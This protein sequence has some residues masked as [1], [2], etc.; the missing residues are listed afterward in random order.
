MGLRLAGLDFLKLD[1]GA[2]EG[3]SL[4]SNRRLPLLMPVSMLAP[5]VGL[6]NLLWFFAGAIVLYW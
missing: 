5:P 2:H 4:L 6:T 3:K 1:A